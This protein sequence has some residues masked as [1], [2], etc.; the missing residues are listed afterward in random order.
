MYPKLKYY[1]QMWNIYSYVLINF[2]EIFWEELFSSFPTPNLLYCMSCATLLGNFTIENMNIEHLLAK[3]AYFKV[4]SEWKPV[5][6]IQSCNPHW[7]IQND[8]ENQLIYAKIIYSECP[9]KLWRQGITCIFKSVWQFI[10]ESML[11]SPRNLSS[12]KKQQG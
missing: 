5:P 7:A 1:F 6:A 2:E 11:Q 3:T 10:L 12:V 4:T 8:T 9:Q